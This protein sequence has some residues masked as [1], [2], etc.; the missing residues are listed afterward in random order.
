MVIC[1]S[2]SEIVNQTIPCETTTPTRASTTTPIPDETTTPIT[3][4]STIRGSTTTPAVCEWKNFVYAPGFEII[5]Y[6]FITKTTL[7]L[8]I[9]QLYS[10]ILAYVLF[11]FTSISFYI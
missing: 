2:N 3:V 1:D 7:L 11:I 4:T 5:K 10:Y 9:V 6:I 8:I